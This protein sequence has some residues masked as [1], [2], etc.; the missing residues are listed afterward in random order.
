MKRSECFK[1]AQIA[2]VESTTITG[3]DKLEILKELIEEEKLS[4]YVEEQKE[5][6][7]AGN[8]TV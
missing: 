2:V 4:L 7:G 5:K 3:T 8:G 1:A 6:R